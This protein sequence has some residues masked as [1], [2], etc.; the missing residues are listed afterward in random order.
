VK[1]TKKILRSAIYTALSGNITYNAVNVPVVDERL[2]S[3]QTANNFIVLSTQQETDVENND[4][5][6]I[7]D[8]YIDIEIVN[9]TMS[10]VSK[11]VNDDIY[12]DVMEILIP[13]PYDAG[14]SLPAG[15]QLSKAVR[16]S[17]ITQNISLSPTE[18]VLVTIVKLVFTIIQI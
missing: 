17:S 16:Q 3:T 2:R 1:D 7:T 8:S 12:E 15:F 18:S 9:K 4:C 5:A 11:D 10:E 13:T 14:F 6:F